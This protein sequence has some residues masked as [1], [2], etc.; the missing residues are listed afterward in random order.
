MYN[1]FA[2]R[3]RRRL[4]ACLVLAGL[5][6]LVDLAGFVKDKISPVVSLLPPSIGS[7][8]SST[9]AQLSVPFNDTIPVSLIKTYNDHAASSPSSP[10][11]PSP[12][13]R[14]AHNKSTTVYTVSRYGRSGSVLL[15]VV[16]TH[17]IVYRENKQRRSDLNTT[18]NQ[19]V[20]GGACRDKQHIDQAAWALKKPNRDVIPP[21]PD[22]LRNLTRTLQIDNLFL[23]PK[24]PFPLCDVVNK[25]QNTVV[26]TRQGS[27]TRDY[28]DL[29]TPDWYALFRQTILTIDS[30]S[31][32]ASTNLSHHSNLTSTLNQISS[33]TMV[34]SSPPSNHTT[35]IAANDIQVVFYVRRGDIEPCSERYGYRYLPN[36]YYG[37]VWNYLQQT[38]L[39]NSSQPIHLHIISQS[40]SFEPW[41]HMKRIIQSQTAP[42]IKHR[43]TIQMRLDEPIPTVLSFMTFESDILVI[44]KS[45]FSFLPAILNTK[46]LVVYTPFYNDPLPHWHVVP[47]WLQY[48]AAQSLAEIQ[49]AKCNKGN[50]TQM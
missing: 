45:T 23:D 47:E 22:E 16:R 41:R 38:I 32:V 46:A 43:L 24:D 10:S 11:S 33:K 42:S 48:V 39:S 7:T 4:L 20:Y 26:W 14:T 1:W 49:K 6:Q 35:S 34:D 27:S 19:L 3:D 40:K 18:N 15:E 9:I 2:N 29:L 12:S 21:T 17:A 13:E 28:K 5:V 25:S 36:I 30:R 44:S 8:T 50:E 31:H 37:K